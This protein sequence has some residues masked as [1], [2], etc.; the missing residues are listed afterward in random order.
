MDLSI[1]IPVYNTSREKLER[2]FRSLQSLKGIAYEVILV[3]DGSTEETGAFCRDYANTQDLFRYMHQENKGV[4]AA[5]NAGI[6]HA[7]GAYVMFVDADDEM[8]GDTVELQYMKGDWDIVFFD[9]ELY[10]ERYYRIRNVFSNALAGSLRKKDCIKA[11]CRNELNTVCAKLYRRS[12]LLEKVIRFDESMVS[13]EDAKFAFQAILA[14]ETMYYVPV[15]TYRYFRSP[16][17]GNNRLMRYPQKLQEN[18]VQLYTLRK[19]TVECYGASWGMTDE[20]QKQA[21]VSA[22]EILIRFLFQI[23]GSLLILKLPYGKRDEMVTS[24]ISEVYKSYSRNFPLKTRVKCLFLRKDWK[25]V[26]GMYAFCRE[27][28]IRERK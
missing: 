18:A 7:A 15:P 19:E 26:M 28:Y 4:S 11:A 6:N 27:V 8:I 25:L 13:A 20:E 24:M 2:C 1:I 9:F 21:R 17:S 10:E 23:R 12:M 3:D 22:A 14:A 5:R 16:G